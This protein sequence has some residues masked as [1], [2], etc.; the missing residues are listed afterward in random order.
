ML[1]NTIFSNLGIPIAMVLLFAVIMVWECIWKGI[2]LWKSGIHKQ[3]GWFIGIFIFN[4]L[5]ILPIIYLLFFQKKSEVRRTPRKHSRSR[6][7][8]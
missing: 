5:G 8:R 1:Y 7:R 3:L 4:T 2:G 6:R